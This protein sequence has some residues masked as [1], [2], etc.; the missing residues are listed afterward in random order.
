RVE[1]S[2]ERPRLCEALSLAADSHRLILVEAP[3]GYGKSTMLSDWVRNATI[4]SAWLTL[5]RF[6]ARPERLFRGVLAAVQSAAAGMSPA[7]NEVLLT[8]DRAHT[9]DEV[10]SY[11]NLLAGLDL[12]Q[13]PLALV[14]DDVHL[15]G[16]GLVDGIVGILTSSAS[17]ALRLILSGRDHSSLRL[18]K[19]RYADGL[20]EFRSEDLA[21]TLR[22]ARDLAVNLKPAPGLDVEALWRATAGWPVALHAG[23][24]GVPAKKEHEDGSGGFTPQRAF[25]EYIAE[26]VLGQLDP[27]LA[28]FV[29]RATTCDWLEHELA[30]ALSGVQSGGILL[31]ECM[32]NGL[33]IEEID[34]RSDGPVYQWQA[35]FAAQC[36]EILEERNR[37]LAEQL[38]RVAARFYQDFDVTE[39]VSQALQGR[40]PQQAVTSLVAHWLDYLLRNGLSSLEQLCLDLPGPW[41]DHA[42]VLMI[43]SIC[44]ALS[45]DAPSA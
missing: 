45:G 24:V 18:E 17:P 34:V 7:V 36:R 11:D 4:P 38:H 3:A 37:V 33:F 9:H 30:I 42:G 22:E 43:R 32:R 29:L 40:E 2:I 28:D 10:A 25:T 21:F 19:L 16:P 26:E 41:S 1:L 14:I 20:E 44:R 27:S 15:A 23:L 39:S 12:L 6:D 35:L 13:E 8:A 5:D 31:Q